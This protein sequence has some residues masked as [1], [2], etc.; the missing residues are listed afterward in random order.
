VRDVEVRGLSRKH[1]DAGLRGGWWGKN[2]KLFSRRFHIAKPGFY[3]A[4]SVKEMP[5]KKKPHF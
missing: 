5:L 3:A 4:E 2:K 1:S